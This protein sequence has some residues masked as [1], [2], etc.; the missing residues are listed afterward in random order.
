MK[1]VATVL[2][3]ACL[4]VAGAAVAQDKKMAADK[5]MTAKEC[6]DYMDMAKKDATKKDAKKDTACAE[7]MKKADAGKKK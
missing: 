6:Q 4:A 5:P 7:T 2:M 3:S 1:L